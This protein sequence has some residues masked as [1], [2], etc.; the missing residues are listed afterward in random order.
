MIDRLLS[1]LFGGDKMNGELIRTFWSKIHPHNF[2]SNVIFA[3]FS[4][5]SI[6]GLLSRLQVT[7]II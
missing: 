1:H 4:S 3:Q 2:S 5:I 6:P 7:Y